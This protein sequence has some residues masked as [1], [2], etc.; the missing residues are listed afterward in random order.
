MSGTSSGLVQIEAGGSAGVF[1]WVALTATGTS[2]LTT[3]LQDNGFTVSAQ[4]DP[5]VDTYVSEERHFLAVRLNDTDAATTVREIPP[6]QFTVQTTERYYPMAISTISAAAETEVLM[7]LW[8]AHRQ[9]SANPPTEIIDPQALHRVDGSPS[10]TNYEEL[11]REIIASHGPGTLI[12]EYSSPWEWNVDSDT[13]PGMEWP[14]GTPP[15]I[16]GDGYLTRL[17]TLL[18]PAEMDFDYTFQD[19]PSDDEVSQDI[20][21]S[22]H[23]EANR[24]NGV[25]ALAPLAIF[26]VW[27]LAGR[28]T[29]L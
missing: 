4:A 1:E 27:R 19:A 20:W 13:V 5:V 10:G 3:W 17:R 25:I 15:G 23:P 7:Y 9:E 12:T 16:Q 26:T 8:A 22:A 28:R 6:F 18:S 21:I 2:A 14:D 29:P 24:R 11:F